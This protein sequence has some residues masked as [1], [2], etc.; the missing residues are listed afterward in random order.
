M[1]KYLLYLFQQFNNTKGYTNP[2]YNSKMYI[3]EFCEWIINQKCISKYYVDLL[4]QF[5]LD[6]NNPEVAEIG[7]GKYDSIALPNTQIISEFGETLGHQNKE[8]VIYQGEPIIIGS[9][10]FEG[11]VVDKF[12][13][14]NPYDCRNLQDWEKLHYANG[15][16]CIGMYGRKIDKDFEYKMNI[17]KCFE[18]LLADDS[19]LEYT[20]IDDKYLAFIKSDKKILR[21]IKT[22]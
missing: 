10:L 18:S 7:K 3:E 15:D 6:I 11:Q 22:L 9:K 1:S 5:D 12:I 21:K 17:L 16:I 8:L 14:Q 19:I 13:T 20:T 2:D 4:S